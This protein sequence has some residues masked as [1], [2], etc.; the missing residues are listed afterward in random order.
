MVLIS[1]F[2]KKCRIAVLR[3]ALLTAFLSALFL[4]N[5]EPIRSVGNNIYTLYVNGIEIGKVDTP[6]E[7]DKLMIDARREVAGAQSSLTLIDVDFEIVG[8]EVYYGTVSDSEVMLDM[9]KTELQKG[10]KETMTHSYTVK[11]DEYM[12]NLASAKEV[13]ELLEASIRRYD[14]DNLYDVTLESDVSREVPVLI[15][16]VEKV[17]T[18]GESKNAPVSA[19]DFLGSDGIF[20]ELEIAL[21]GEKSTY[22]ENFTTY[23]YGLTAISFA[24]TIEIVES[25]LPK[26][27][28]STLEEAID[29][30]TK[31]KEQK[32]TYEVVSG[33]T[34]SKISKNTGISIDD[35]VALNDNLTSSSSKI[36]V[37]D[38][39]II[40]VPK[41]E[42][43][44]AREEVV[45]Y[46]GTYEA[47][48]QYI[49]NSSWYTT[50][51]V[52]RQDPLSGFH[53]AV[54][55]VSYLDG[56]VVSTEILYEEVVAEA[57]P[58][59]VEK[60]TKI[61]PTY[62]WPVS[63]GRITSSFGHRSA[64]T[65]GATTS[66]K[67]V[68]IGVSLG[69]S[70]VASCGGTVSFAGWNGSYGYVIYIDHPDGRQTRYAHLSKVLVS[71]GTKVSQGQ[72]IALSG[73]SGRSTGPHLHFEM[74]INGTPVNPTKY[75]S[76]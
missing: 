50:S 21:S 72:K 29:E 10:V 53:K 38:E 51:Q 55:K 2:H 43:S 48:I 58:K 16:V 75:T 31:D 8:E 59:I 45:Y 27:Q 42:L 32:T 40:T 76:R 57:V 46:E 66:H 30:V 23:E 52:T 36:R 63:G 18:E 13:V 14:T 15:P 35:I 61:P 9:I 4:P 22:T 12:V 37:G 69:T 44:V 54:E 19:S 56:E 34:L 5:I 68:D 39:L 3:V 62:I 49:Y 26:S 17:E 1:R 33:D 47:D 25:Y 71:K 67:G 60:G 41:P 28:I 74:R 65:A 7:A 6:D 11:I 24:N 64:P 73:N 70:V 20:Q